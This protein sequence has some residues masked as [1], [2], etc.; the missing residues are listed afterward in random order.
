MWWLLLAAEFVYFSTNVFS[1]CFKL[2]VLRI[3]HNS[4]KMPCND[5]GAV[6]CN[7]SLDITP[8]SIT[9]N[10]ISARLG[11]KALLMVYSDHLPSVICVLLACT[12]PFDAG[13]IRHEAV[14]T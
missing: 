11:T 4:S 6:A 13:V 2:I 7:M 10:G 3:Y 5:R 8:T 9:T 12:F 1:I 14:C